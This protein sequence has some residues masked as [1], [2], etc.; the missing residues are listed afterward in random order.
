MCLGRI[1]ILLK[2]ILLQVGVSLHV[3]AVLM[4]RR[5]RRNICSTRR[6]EQNA[7]K[8]DRFGHHGR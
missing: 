3:Q 1:A 6:N 2:M 7:C 4:A 5:Q 8:E